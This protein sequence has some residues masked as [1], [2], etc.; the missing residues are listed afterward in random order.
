[1]LKKALCEE[2]SQCIRAGRQQVPAVDGWPGKPRTKNKIMNIKT[3]TT[4]ALTALTT[5]SILCAFS[6]HAAVITWGT[7]TYDAADTDVSTTGT[8]VAAYSLDTAAVTI[9][10]VAFAA[11]SASVSSLG[12]TFSMTGFTTH[13][14]S[15]GGGTSTPYKNLSA[16]YQTLLASGDYVGNVNTTPVVTM[17]NLTFGEKYAVQIWANDSRTGR[18]AADYANVYDTAGGNNVAV[19]YNSTGAVGGV[20]QWTIGTFIADGTTQSFSILGNIGSGQADT[21]LNAIQL[22]DLGPATFGIGYWNGL[23]GDNALNYTSLN[24]CTN[25]D[26]APVGTASSLTTLE[27]LTNACYFA[28]SYYANSI[29]NA[30]TANNL[31]VGTGG[32]SIGTVN[33]LNSALTYTLTSSDANGITGTTVVNKSGSGT[34]ILDGANTYSG[35]TL[36]SLGTVQ[37]GAGDANGSLGS[38]PVTNVASLVFNRNDSPT[39][40]NVISGA[41]TLT[42]SGPGTLT[43]S[44]VNTYTGGTTISAGTLAINSSASETLS[45]VMS[46]AGAL[47][48]NGSGT[49]TLSG[50][51]T[52]NGG[53]TINSGCSVQLTSGGYIT[54]GAGVGPV[55]ING[56]GILIL[57]NNAALANTSVTGNTTTSSINVILTTGNLWL[58]NSLANF[59]GTFNVNYANISANGGQLVV[60]SGSGI[61]PNINS[62]AIWQIYPGSVVDFNGG[63]TDPAIVN[64]YGLPYASAADG[65][66][67]LDGSTQSGNVILQGNSEIGNGNAAM[68]TITG[69]ISDTG[70]TYGFTVLAAHGLE[71]QAVNTYHGATVISNGTLLLNGLGTAF[72]SSSSGS[73]FNTSGISLANG[74]TFDV[75]GVTGYGNGYPLGPSQTLATLGGSATINGN[76][77]LSLGGPIS[78]VCNSTGTPLTVTGGTLTLN[79]NPVTVTLTSPTTVSGGEVLLISGVTGTVGAVTF[80]QTSGAATTQPTLSVSG[81]NLYLVINS[82]VIT[83]YGP[84]TATNLFIFGGTGAAVQGVPPTLSVT[85]VGNPTP[86]YQWYSNGIAITTGPTVGTSASLTYPTTGSGSLPAGR[87]TNYCLVQN[88]FGRTSNIWV[89]DVVSTNG[90]AAYPAAV[91]ATPG[92]PPIAY[93]RLDE[94]SQLAGNANVPVN[95]WIGGNIGTYTNVTLG[96]TSYDAATD[97]FETSADFGAFATTDSVG[98]IPLANANLNMGAGSGTAVNLSVE[99]WINAGP[100]TTE[101]DATIVSQGINGNNDTFVLDCNANGSATRYLRFY[102]GGSGHSVSQATSTILPNSTWQHVMGVLNESAGN[103]TLYVNGVSAATATIGTVGLY[104]SGS[105]EP[106]VIGGEQSGSGGFTASYQWKGFIDDVAIYNY[107]LTAAEVLAHYTAAVGFP[108]ITLAASTNVNAGATVTLTATVAGTAPVTQGWSDSGNTVGGLNTVSNATTLTFVATATDTYTI[109]AT[110]AFTSPTTTLTPPSASEVVTVH[111]GAPSF[112]SPGNN[113]TPSSITVYAGT[114]VTFS[115]LAY[116]TAPLGYLSY[117]WYNNAGLMSGQTA[118]NLTLIATEGVSTY[119]CKVTGSSTATSGTA[120]LVGVSRPVD[121]YA[122]TILSNNPIAYWRLDE[123]DNGQNNGNSG[124]IAYNYVGGHNCSYNGVELDQPGVALT[125]SNTGAL[126]GTYAYPNSYA[127]ELVLSSIGIQPIDLAATTPEYSVEAWVMAYGSQATGAGILA[128]GYGGAGEQFILQSIGDDFEFEFHQANNVAVVCQSGVADNDGNWHH[129]VG[130]YDGAGLVSGAGAHF[131]VDGG[132]VANAFAVSGAGVEDPG[133]S[134][135]QDLVSIGARASG[136]TP[137]LTDQFVGDIAEVAIYNF[138]LSANQVLADYTAG[139][140]LPQIAQILPFS[141]TNVT[142]IAK[143]SVTLTWTSQP[144]YSYQVQ[145]A[146]TLYGSGPTTWSNLGPAINA[147]GTSTSY[148]DTSTNVTDGLGAFYQVI[149]Y[150]YYQGY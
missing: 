138:P 137:S 17:Q 50:A 8:L 6:A 34:L 98:Y 25:S 36:I 129:L 112:A 84:Y 80:I 27:I 107:A 132:D 43:L 127:G 46:G 99:C 90:L 18:P 61:T 42:W 76:L 19:H 100:Q 60:G 93:W 74:T 126:F 131:Y 125:D 71:L 70:G 82:P 120:T 96:G 40:N 86:T 89:I 28:D 134:A 35:G 130:V 140:G 72:G 26:T 11:G 97:P 58:T 67:R 85:A 39:V 149:G 59:Q 69:V 51:S 79:N 21:Y 75:S 106:I 148:T 7:P 150:G 78:L 63:Q 110:N 1:M 128:K 57:S 133:S 124:G 117:Q 145:V 147:T 49:L 54:G 144:N 24:F 65:A 30:V 116:G 64:L 2:N 95:D 92:G 94:S 44:A 105:S 5:A 32:I 141:I 115:V 111:T 13:Y 55:T 4:T 114:A 91:L 109:R 10:T 9:N 118:T 143:V 52:F 146:S 122:L 41:G 135:V 103:L 136:N 23:G 31:T 73:I 81:G 12:T 20:G 22:R 68:S 62:S 104:T 83:S 142:S 53:L 48:Q 56:N 15:F 139:T 33:F 16:N 47:Q 77:D 119:Y 102:V 88:S 108:V 87:Q 66:L 123:P 113:I 121:L 101:A 29:L 3:F 45:G 38:G 14:A 37:V